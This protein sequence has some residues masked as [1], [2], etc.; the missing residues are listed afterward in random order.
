[1]NQKLSLLLGIIELTS[2]ILLQPSTL[3]LLRELR[4]T[5]ITFVFQSPFNVY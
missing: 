2:L 5:I 4:P 3:L 1:M